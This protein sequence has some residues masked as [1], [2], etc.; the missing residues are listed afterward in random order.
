MRVYRV[1][2]GDQYLNNRGFSKF[3]NA[4]VGEGNLR[5]ALAYWRNQGVDLS[6]L[7]IEE[8][9]LSDEFNAF[10]YANFNRNTKNRF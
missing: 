3:G 9:E 10:D 8:Y 1:R 5:R 7:T 4:Y 2:K 6:K